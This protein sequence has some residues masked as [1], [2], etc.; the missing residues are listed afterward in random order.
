MPLSMLDARASLEFEAIWH[1]I[2]R[3]LEHLLESR[4]ECSAAGVLSNTAKLNCS[5]AAWKGETE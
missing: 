5:Q 1:A 2:Q 4:C 3:G